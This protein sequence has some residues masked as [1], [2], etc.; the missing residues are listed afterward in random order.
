[1]I[2]LKMRPKKKKNQAKD[3]RSTT[4]L[5]QIDTEKM[6][7]RNISIKLLKYKDTEN[8]HYKRTIFRL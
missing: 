4:N 3:S 5:K 6:T 1:M 2:I 7:S 8:L